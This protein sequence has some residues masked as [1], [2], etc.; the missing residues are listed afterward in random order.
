LRAR[1]AV[2]RSRRGWLSGR[3]GTE[4][5]GARARGGPL[6]TARRAGEAK[7]L[8]IREIRPVANPCCPLPRRLPAAA[9]SSPHLGLRAWQRSPPRRDAAPRMREVSK[10]AERVAQDVCIRRQNHIHLDFRIYMRST[11][12]VRRTFAS[13]MDTGGRERITFIASVKPRTPVE[14]YTRARTRIE[15]SRLRRPGAPRPE[16]IFTSSRKKR[17]R[18]VKQSP[19]S[20][21]LA[22]CR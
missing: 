21:S 22:A 3:Y 19:R 4:E 7:S 11:F 8:G 5:L 12:Y 14:K 2:R 10:R 13:N 15:P 20:R 9:H 6:P 1:A 17:R 16:G 18:R